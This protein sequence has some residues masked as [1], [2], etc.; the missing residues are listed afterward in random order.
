[1]VYY[2]AQLGWFRTKNT[3]TCCIIIYHL[4]ISSGPCDILLCYCNQILIIIIIIY[5]IQSVLLTVLYMGII[6]QFRDFIPLYSDTFIV[7]LRRLKRTQISRLVFSLLLLHYFIVIGIQT[8][9][10][11]ISIIDLFSRL[12]YSILCL[13]L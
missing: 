9:S 5:A 10:I 2:I 7:Y 6:I 3:D 4:F 8:F 11:S 1:M 13:L 12:N